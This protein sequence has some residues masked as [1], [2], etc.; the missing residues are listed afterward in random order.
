MRAKENMD[1]WVTQTQAFSSAHSR[2]SAVLVG[3]CLYE[4]KCDLSE[5]RRALGVKDL[6]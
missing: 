4:S 6:V 3:L 5:L 2:D 1:F